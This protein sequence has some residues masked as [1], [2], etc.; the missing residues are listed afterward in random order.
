VFL[1]DASDPSLKRGGIGVRV[2][3]GRGQ[4]P[5]QVAVAREL[6]VSLV[7]EL[8]GAAVDDPRRVESYPTKIQQ[9][10]TPTQREDGTL[11]VSFR[12]HRPVS[13]ESFVNPY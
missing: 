11:H 8:V 12:L 3:L 5:G 10:E 6:D 1:K 9:G 13:P 7:E 4:T 2:A